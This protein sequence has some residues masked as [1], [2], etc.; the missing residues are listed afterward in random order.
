[1]S[2]HLGV[3]G[4]GVQGWGVQ[5]WGVQGWG[6][7]GWRRR[8]LVL[9]LGLCAALALPPLYLV[10]FLIPAFSGLVLLIENAPS[11]KAAF[12]AGWWFGFGFYTAGLYWIGNAMLVDAARFGW[13]IPFAV[14]GLSGFLALFLGLV[15][16][17]ARAIGQGAGRGG[18]ALAL[19]GAWVV[20]EW[21]RS[22]IF[23][24]FPWNLIGTVWTFSDAMMQPAALIGAYGLSLITLAAA[25]APSLLWKGGREPAVRLLVLA[26]YLL[27][28]AGGAW[29]FV[30]LAGAAPG[31]VENVR[32]RLV[33]GNIDQSQKWRDELRRQHFEKHIALSRLPPEDPSARAPTHVIW[34]ETAVPY[35]IDHDIRVRMRLAEAVPPG[36]LL[37]TGAPRATAPGV[38]P[39]Q[40][41][42]SLEAIDGN[43]VLAGI[44]DKFHLVPFGEYVP[45]RGL[46][47][48]ER[49]VPGRGDF[50]TG[51]GPVTIDLP[52]LPPVGPLICYEA[53]FPAAVIDP[54]RRPDWLLIVTN[55]GWFG[56]SA[57]PHQHF[58]ASRLRAVEQGL[59]LVRAANT[60]ISGVVD[61]LG[62]VEAR[63]GLGETGVLDADLP[64]PLEGRTLY[65]QLGDGLP[66]GLAAILLLVEYLAGIRAR[67]S[68][69]SRYSM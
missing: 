46:L 4:W 57:G 26:P 27:L 31:A 21:V 44:Y 56:I 22:W 45:L 29:G 34:P 66:L 62:R 40:V 18:I 20:Q 11:R 43:G 23:T 15:A 58:A 35:L 50:S 10:F 68:V 55:D 8:G 60:G 7:Q 52:G 41:W 3:Q 12:G 64:K 6:V 25:A 53:I 63:L 37:I 17:A 30:R 39:F 61:A 5:G 14:F 36:G 67:K 65:S 51:P 32:L 69:R 16:L 59:P 49:I 28:L 47:P 42:N 54:K 13:M 24:G 9:L 19:G 1:M 33:Q 48:I 2:Q 38:E